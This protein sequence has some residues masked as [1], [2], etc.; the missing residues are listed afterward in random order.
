M[1]IDQA[2]AIVLR[3]YNFGDQDKVVVFFTRDKGLLRGV[4]KG[5]RKFGNRFGSSLEPMSLVRVFYYE[6]ERKDLVTVSNCDL[7]E[8]FFEAQND[9]KVS[10]TVSYFAEL[11][12]EFSPSRSKDDVLFR[13]LLSV[14]RCLAA[15][16][17]PG[18]LARY[19]EAWFLRSTGSF[20]TWRRCKKC[21]K[22]PSG[23]AWL[24]PEKGRGL[25][26]RMRSGP[27]GRDPAGDRLFPEVGPRQ[28][29]V[30]GLSPIVRSGEPGRGERGS[31]GDDHL[32]SR[33]GTA[34]PP[35]FKKRDVISGSV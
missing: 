20:P 23:P 18:F 12:E 28:P 2:E 7:L 32:P 29:S 8:S 14:L 27:E 34:N 19:F 17:D 30:R 4:A 25:L 9:L 26:R 10:C 16:G 11:I 3:T 22:P 21:R 6:K 1:P 33:E 35:L 31:A 24:S 13:L 15:K 5:A